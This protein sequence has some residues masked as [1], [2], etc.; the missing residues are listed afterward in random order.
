MQNA[1][2]PK[3]WQKIWLLKTFKI[4]IQKGGPN[5]SAVLQNWFPHEIKSPPG[6]FVDI[7][8]IWVQ[9]PWIMQNTLNYNEWQRILVLK[10]FKIE[11]K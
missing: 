3:E 4:E 7:L 6:K 5:N 10:T 1:L 8:K 2:N 11:T 9:Y